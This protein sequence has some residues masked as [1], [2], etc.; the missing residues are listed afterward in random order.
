MGLGV[1][2]AMAAGVPVVAARSGGHL[3]T[4]G[5]LDGALLYDPGESPEAASMLRRLLS[6]EQRAEL[7]EAGRRLVAG[8]F[9][10]QRQVDQLVLE[11]Q[12]VLDD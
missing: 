9:S 11:Y 1:L 12:R 2:E 10:I 4:V 5:R 8:S 6:R 7:S 3:E